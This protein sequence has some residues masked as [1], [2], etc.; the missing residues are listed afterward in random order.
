MRPIC[1][2]LIEMR[3]RNRRRR[4]KMQAEIELPLSSDQIFRCRLSFHHQRRHCS[5]IKI[6]ISNV[7]FGWSFTL[8]IINFHP[9]PSSSFTPRR[10]QL[11]T[12]ASPSLIDFI[13]VNNCHQL[14][15]P[16]STITTR[17]KKATLKYI[18]PTRENYTAEPAYDRIRGNNNLYLQ[19]VSH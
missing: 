8:T 16:S 9:S 1:Q 7:I 19:G 10:Q 17:L 14:L 2:A 3:L 18:Q 12:S 11:S 6:D 13:S 15:T 4:R 5:S